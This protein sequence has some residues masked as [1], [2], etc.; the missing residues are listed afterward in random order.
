MPLFDPRTGRVV[1]E[2]EGGEPVLS[3][4][5]AKNNPEFTAAAVNASKTGARLNIPFLGAQPQ[6]TRKFSNG[7]YVPSTSSSIS[8]TSINPT[9]DT[10][11][12]ENEIK[13][14][15]RKFDSLRSIRAQVSITEVLDAEADYNEV[16]SL[17][18]MS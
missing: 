6:P 15:S 17:G 4:R 9:L 16:K 11:N 7:G 5:F 10:T 1:A 18:D 2:L 8:S 13:A 12:L 14:M 3:N